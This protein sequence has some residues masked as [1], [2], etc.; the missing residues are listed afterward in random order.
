M[1]GRKQLK[2]ADMEIS[3]LLAI[4]PFALSILRAIYPFALF[5]AEQWRFSLVLPVVRK[6]FR[7]DP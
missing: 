2:K 1:R 6:I 3:I 5:V 4:Y 7:D